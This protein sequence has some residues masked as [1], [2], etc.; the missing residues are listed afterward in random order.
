MGINAFSEPFYDHLV[1]STNLG[2]RL[3]A[4]GPVKAG[5]I[6]SALYFIYSSVPKA[7]PFAQLLDE[8]FSNAPSEILARLMRHHDA[9]SLLEALF[10]RIRQE[11]GFEHVTQQDVADL[12]A[13]LWRKQRNE[14][15]AA[16]KPLLP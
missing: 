7:S 15:S 6:L 10:A 2:E 8:L 9:R 13:A 4:L 11:K 5:A 3:R 16:F 14:N 1:G 12:M